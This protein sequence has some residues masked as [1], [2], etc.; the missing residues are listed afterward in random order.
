MYEHTVIYLAL[1]G[2]TAALCYALY[3]LMTDALA[4][5]ALHGIS[6]GFVLFGVTVVALA[7][8]F[9]AWA[10]SVKHD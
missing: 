2:V 10:E 1:G 7:C 5:L 9:M 4:W 3:Q 8:A 6:S